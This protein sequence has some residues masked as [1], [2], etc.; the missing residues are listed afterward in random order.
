[1]RGDDQVLGPVEVC[2]AVAE[3]LDRSAKQTKEARDDARLVGVIMTR[4]PHLGHKQEDRIVR[5]LGLQALGI[6]HACQSI[7]MSP[8]R[9]AARKSLVG[10]QGLEKRALD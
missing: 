5:T 6:T 4:A 2:E 1:V 8:M 3:T 9:T 7:S 10:L